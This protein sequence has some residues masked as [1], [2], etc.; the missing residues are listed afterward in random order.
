MYWNKAENRRDSEMPAGTG[1]HEILFL[2]LFAAGLIFP[3]GN[4]MD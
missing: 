4:K 3:D 1:G 2:L